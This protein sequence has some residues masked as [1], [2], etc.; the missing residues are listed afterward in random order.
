MH[1]IAHRVFTALALA[2]VALG[3]AVSPLT[4]RAAGGTTDEKPVEL[5]QA[6]VDEANNAYNNNGNAA[7]EFISM[8]DT[9][10]ASYEQKDW[11]FQNI[12]EWSNK[13]GFKTG[14]V[15]M[16][17]DVEAN[18]REEQ[19]GNTEKFYTAVS[20]LVHE[21]FPGI[22]V[23]YSLGN[24]DRAADMISL[25]DQLH[26]TET[27]YY[28]NNQGTSPINYHTQ[29][30]G[31]DFITLDYHNYASYLRSELAAIKARS[32]YDPKKP[33]FI[34][35]HSGLNG[36]TTGG[37]QDIAGPQI[38]SILA[39]WPQAIVGTA[40]SHYSAEVETGIYQKD[41]TVYNNGSMDYLE[42][43]GSNS[44][45]GSVSWIQGNLADKHYELTC[46]FITVQK[47]GSV[48]IR[49]FDVTNK[50]WMGKP[51][52][53]EPAKGKAG[54][55]YTAD[56]R[57]KVAPWFKEGSKIDVTNVKDTTA[58][59]TFDQAVDNQLVEYYQ[60]TVRDFLTN[61][62]ATY[63]VS[64]ENAEL[65][66]L[67]T[68]PKGWTGTFKAY[69]RYYIRPY[70]K[71]MKF[72]F[73]SLAP[74]TRYRV[75]V[76]AFDSFDNASTVEDTVFKTTGTTA[77]VPHELAPTL[78]K[79]RFL[80]MNFDKSD[81]TDA[82]GTVTGATKAGN[83]TFVDG[84][85]GQGKAVHLAAGNGTYLD[86]GKVSKASL[87]EGNSL[88]M[89]FWLNAESTSGDATIISDK[90]WNS[91]GN[92]GWYVGFRLSDLNSVGVN[93]SD[94]TTRLDFDGSASLKNN[95]HLVTVAFDR[96]QQKVFIYLDGKLSA[97]SDKL[98]QL[99]DMATG[100]PVRIGTDGNGGNGN[101]AFTIDGLQM[102]DRALTAD[103]ILSMYGAATYKP[104][105][106]DWDAKLKEAV[107]GANKMLAEV[108]K[109]PA[110][111][112]DETLVARLRTAL[113]A[114]KKASTTEDKQVATAELLY[115]TGRVQES[116]HV[117]YLDKSGFKVVATDSWHGDHNE[118]D[119][120]TG[121]TYAP[122]KAI[123]SNNGTAWHTNWTNDGGTAT[124]P[125]PHFIVID[126]GKTQT[127]T[128]V[129][130]TGRGERD[131][132]KDFAVE[133]ADSLDAL[134]VKDGQGL[135]VD[136]NAPA[137]SAKPSDAAV[138]G[139][140]ADQTSAYATLSQP[141]KGRYVKLTILNTWSGKEWAYT[142]EL[143][144]A[145]QAAKPVE[146]TVTVKAGKGGTVSPSKDVVVSDGKSLTL[147][148]AADK[149]Y[150]LDTVKVTD[151]SGKEVKATV[152][153][154]TGEITIDAVKADLTVTVTFKKAD[155][156]GQQPSGVDKAA[157]NDAIAAAKQILAKADTYKP[158]TIAGLAAKLKA[159]EA[160]A[161]DG[162]ASQGKVDAAAK[163]LE[164]EIAKARPKDDGTNKPGNQGDNNGQGNNEQ[165]NGSNNN[166]V[167]SNNSGSTNQAAS[168]K[169]AS[170]KLPKT[171][172]DNG[173][174]IAGVLVAAVVAI[175]AA[176]IVRQR[177]NQNR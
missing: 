160:L 75:I 64:P 94:G 68:F 45:E 52:I 172:D 151:A 23:Q 34:Q 156:G 72:F 171:G 176:V 33:I 141:V 53:V 124:Y 29:I 113:D 10:V 162:N 115:V 5:T 165:G 127:I 85:E 11:A 95:W 155:N 159:A 90:N 3:M 18:E 14:T 66:T 168:S 167:G 134:G 105:T 67:T 4:A 170:G 27:W 80:D 41:F 92:K 118:S 78:K 91:G 157:L 59:L 37:Y 123:D 117:T 8:S 69:S 77:E 145:A 152:D 28:K 153:A 175:V 51:W 98:G 107:D 50:R 71:Q 74:N 20:R 144:F 62:D 135:G 99:G 46:N 30:N 15:L 6:A 56:K 19:Q 158:E 136:E 110:I 81:L 60:V 149:G 61:K 79:G 103:E 22:P 32:D 12:K 174:I 147:V 112:Y 89:S 128:G 83:V 16:D 97:T 130:R 121:R 137:S 58:D 104:D 146:H 161:A 31:F 119:Y 129:G 166:G 120:G 143:D 70:P 35:I 96:T 21:T 17:G 73:S 43:S 42:W 163:E 36:T 100:L 154:K 139:S 26:G 114:A 177:G 169:K 54:F 57:D 131:Y 38:Q 63:Q 47:D 1:R 25:F 164:A 138:R 55:R 13:I 106:T 173:A 109:D 88:T 84:M 2:V 93:A 44:L 7:L 40:H 65:D 126:L 150:A 9:H 142:A 140:F 116:Q 122:E 87:G 82:A 24:H 76:Q 108:G 111:T 125:L 148:A 102:W 132:I 48:V 133:A 39:D 86:L 101:A 49:R